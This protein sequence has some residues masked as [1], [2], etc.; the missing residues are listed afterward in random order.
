MP[1]KRDRD[2]NTFHDV[3]VSASII[4]SSPGTRSRATSRRSSIT[5][6]SSKKWA[7]F[8]CRWPK[9]MR[10]VVL[11]DVDRC[12]AIQSHARPSRSEALRLTARSK[13][14]KCKDRNQPSTTPLTFG[15]RRSVGAKSQAGRPSLPLKN[16][17]RLS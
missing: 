9:I 2:S 16:V 3:L 13:R 7:F 14:G 11:C 15:G 12:S 4:S 5:S 1:T 6:S 17:S 10:V 8:P